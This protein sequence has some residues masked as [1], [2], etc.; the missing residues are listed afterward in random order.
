MVYSVKN[1]AKVCYFFSVC[2]VVVL[3]VWTTAHF[4]QISETNAEKITLPVFSFWGFLEAARTGIPF[5]LYLSVLLSLS[6]TAR[7]KIRVI[8]SMVTIF[9]LAIGWTFLSAWAVAHIPPHPRIS[10]KPVSLV[11]D[12]LIVTTDRGQ[13]AVFLSTGLPSSSLAFTGALRFD[14]APETPNSAKP[15]SFK[16]SRVPLTKSIANDFLRLQENLIELQEMG[17]A[18]FAVY[19]VG[20]VILLV[21]TRFIMDLSV[22]ALVNLFLGFIA[23]YGISAFELFMDSNWRYAD[24][25]SFVIDRTPTPLTDSLVLCVAGLFVMGVSGA[26]YLARKRRRKEA[27]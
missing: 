5:A 27:A 17:F 7:K 18:Y 6:Y 21:S 24:L 2:F 15:L 16:V 23:F 1:I 14:D 9:L 4:F 11:R 22:W 12:G 3:L 10:G 25:L 20:L 8:P 26:V 19:A 13:K